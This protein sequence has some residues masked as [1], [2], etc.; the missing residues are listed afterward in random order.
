MSFTI[1]YWDEDDNRYVSMARYKTYKAAHKVMVED[2][3]EGFELDGHEIIT[4][5]VIEVED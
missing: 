3:E 4:A 2:M 1:E 5:H